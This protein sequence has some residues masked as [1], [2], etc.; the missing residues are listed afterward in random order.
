MANVSYRKGKSIDLDKAPISDG[1]IL[2]AEDTGE[3]YIDNSEN[4]RIPIM[5]KNKFKTINGQSVIVESPDETEISII[6]Q[7]EET[8]DLNNYVTKADTV[9]HKTGDISNPGEIFN[10]YQEI[11]APLG[12]IA[13]F[14]IG[15]QKLPKNTANNYG[16]A[17]GVSTTATGRG[18]HAEGV[19]TK[20]EGEA[21]HAEGAGVIATAGGTHAEGRGINFKVTI[22]KVSSETEIAYTKIK[23]DQE[24]R[25][26][27]YNI[28]IQADENS[29]PALSVLTKPAFIQAQLESIKHNA[30]IWI[31]TNSTNHTGN[32]YIVETVEYDKTSN[33]SIYTNLCRLRIIGCENK[34]PRINEIATVIMGGALSYM[35]HIEGNYNNTVD[36]DATSLSG[37]ENSGLQR[38]HAEGSRTLAMGYASHS[39]GELTSAIGNMSHAEGSET[40][41]E[42]G[43]SH[44]EGVGTYTT[45][46][47]SHAEGGWTEAHGEYAHAEGYVTKARGKYSHA[48]GYYTEAGQNGQTV[49]GR[50]NDNKENTLFEVGN[51]QKSSSLSNAFAVYE[52]GHAEVQKIGTT[53]NSVVTNSKFKFYTSEEDIEQGLPTGTIIFIVDGWNG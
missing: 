24:Y 9:G 38:Q 7:G 29:L 25:Y 16:H 48:G 39:E 30:V 51:G 6:Y 13:G 34:M 49:I 8:I 31:E 22:T 44:V 43:S 42:G 35:S 33:L 46:Y 21:S 28:E 40:C 17:E 41:A 47:A 14:E 12:T 3:M 32:F 53:E 26:Y 45:K 52:D 27:Y 18:S 5:S 37:S 15:T 4:N 36:I 11:E 10:L 2:I 50:Y 20:A 23:N 1:Q 19:S